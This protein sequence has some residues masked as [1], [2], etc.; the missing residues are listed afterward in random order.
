MIEDLLCA[1]QRSETILDIGAIDGYDPLFYSEANPRAN[2]YCFEPD[3][4]FFSLIQKKVT[5]SGAKNITLLQNAIGSRNKT[6]R[7]SINDDNDDIEMITIDSL[8]LINCDFIKI[9][10]GAVPEGLVLAGA[11]KTIKRYNPAI[12]YSTPDIDH[13]LEK[14][15]YHCRG[16]ERVRL[17]TCH[18]ASVGSSAGLRSPPGSP[19]TSPILP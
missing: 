1:V 5:G 9:G 17:A 11:E 4:R 14:M 7:A 12:L 19:C 8:N 13:I 6:I 10:K 18:Q 15:G 16:N 3:S 2:I